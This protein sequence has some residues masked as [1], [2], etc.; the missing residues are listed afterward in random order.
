MKWRARLLGFL[1][2]CSLLIGLNVFVTI[3]GMYSPLPT[4]EGRAEAPYHGE[5][6]LAVISQP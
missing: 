5:S 3:S 2:I 4:R 1:L 6:T